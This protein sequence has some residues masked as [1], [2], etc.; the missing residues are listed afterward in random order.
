MATQARVE[1]V[2]DETGAIPG[3]TRF[4]QR[5]TAAMQQPTAQ[6]KLLSM[7]MNATGVAGTKAGDAMTVGFQ[8]ANR[9]VLTS[10][11]SVRLL[12]E[13]LGVHVPRAMQRLIAQ[14]E[15][16]QT[17]SKVAFGA[18]AFVG[19]I[20]LATTFGKKI[21][22]AFSKGG[23]TARAMQQAIADANTE[24]K[25]TNDALDVQIAKLQEERAKLEG[26]PRDGIHLALLEDI[27]AADALSEKLNG[28]FAKFNTD[29]VK[30]MGGSLWTNWMKG[31]VR[32]GYEQT[33]V[34][35][36]MRHMG[37]QSSVQ[38]ELGESESFGQS[39]D[40]RREDLRKKQAAEDKKTADSGGRYKG[41]NYENEIKATQ[42]LI[43]EQ[44]KEHATI[45][46]TIDLNKEQAAVDWDKAN[47]A[48]KGGSGLKDQQQGVELLARL[49]REATEAGMQDEEL[50]NQKRI[51]QI[52]EVTAKLKELHDAEKIPAAVQAI[53]D[54]YY[55]E[56][57]QRVIELQNKTALGIER[58]HA[59]T[60]KPGEDKI[61]AEHD[62][63]LNE[64]NTSSTLSPD[65]AS[66]EREAAQ[67]DMNQKLDALREENQKKDQEAA[68]RE[69]ERKA[70]NA[71]QDLQYDRTAAQAERR[72]KQEGLEGWVGEH[73]AATAEIDAQRTEQ[74][75]KLDEDRQKEQL[76]D[77]EYSQRKVDIER[78][79][80][81]QIAEENQRMAHQISQTLQE[82][83]TNPIGF[84][85]SKMQQMFFE[86]V[87]NWIEHSKMFQG[88]FGQTIGSAQPGGGGH[89]SILSSLGIGPRGASTSAAGGG[90]SSSSTG[91]GSVG[92]IYDGGYSPS[93]STGS[94]ASYRPAYTGGAGTSGGGIGSTIS[95]TVGSARGLYSQLSTA[96][97]TPGSPVYGVGDVGAHG[98]IGGTYKTVD[99][100]DGNVRLSG[101]IPGQSAGMA[102]TAM[103]V[104]G[105]GMAGYAAYGD[106]K[107]DFKSGSASGT[108]KGMLGDAMAGAA[109]GSVI[110]GIGTLI[111]AGIGAAVG[112]ASGIT[113]AI[114]GEGGRLAAR[115]YYKKTLFPEMERE[116]NGSGDYQSAISDINKTASGGMSY[117]TGKWGGGSAQWVED[118][119]LRKEQLLAIGQ[120]TAR[121]RGGS[122]AVSLSAGQ[123]HSGTDNISDFGDLA[124]SSNEGFM[125]AMLGEAV[126]NPVAASTHRPAISAMNAGA[127]PDDIAGMYGGGSGSGG[128][129]TH[130]HYSI[131]ALDPKSFDSFLRGG[132]ARTMIKALNQQATRYAGD[133]SGG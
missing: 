30:T 57:G 64:I 122:N 13:D 24:M 65:G 33:M 120:I 114:M 49:Q 48:D 10:V 20:E 131:S 8:K 42:A 23:E 78:S 72:V 16:F 67:Q 85:K 50:A 95:S 80:D 106:T 76:T 132:G 79:A 105:A 25:H 125:H 61:R 84:I 32:T 41:L 38:G 6:A 35:E 116:R 44:V 12:S 60:M 96:R 117:M 2:V 100:G 58:A 81:A 55:E 86:I 74:M 87:A 89:A 14:T 73:K 109:I 88:V 108:M 17:L 94:G 83:F 9:S 11:D 93:T 118:N 82:A 3:L 115:D 111:G 91:V 107:A 22:D 53:N 98:G 18:F 59:G 99:A 130:H 46:K 123:F 15:I 7:E 75:A 31:D 97:N 133:S 27:E 54:A 5:A 129:D 119:Y 66:A 62:L 71:E 127:S 43:D 90:T 29:V 68:D 4:Q 101:D 103:G 26:K 124:T 34:G 56:Q 69:R 40:I 51:D 102:S 36:H 104:A 47:K 63:R 77:Q 39:L 45:Q 1:L 70:R 37:E 121:A 112:L 19:G 21:Y 113:G 110:P 126:V 28:I 52:N 92:G 128:G